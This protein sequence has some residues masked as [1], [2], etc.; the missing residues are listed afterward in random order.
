M[1]FPNYAGAIKPE[2]TVI[3]KKESSKEIY[4][5][6]RNKFY[7]FLTI[8]W[9]QAQI[10]IVIKGKSLENLL[11]I[12]KNQFN[13][14]IDGPNL[15]AGLRTTFAQVDKCLKQAFR[16]TSDRFFVFFIIL[17]IF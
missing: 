5:A 4:R 10:L 11:K 2:Q 12:N 6:P 17:M 16:A 7:N 13:S 15:F 3:P 1:D 9:I 14:S 8:F